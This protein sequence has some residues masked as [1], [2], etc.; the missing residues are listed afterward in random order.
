MQRKIFI[1]FANITLLLS[2][3]SFAG[4]TGY[5]SQPIVNQVLAQAQPTFVPDCTPAIGAYCS[6]TPSV[7]VTAG[8][9][10]PFSLVVI[11]GSILLLLGFLI[12]VFLP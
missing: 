10:I 12:F 4:N 8:T 2:L 11:S 7:P 5:N 3:V 6:P 1:L 9:I